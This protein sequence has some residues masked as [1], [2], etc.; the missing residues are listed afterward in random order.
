M[1]YFVIR[2]TIAFVFVFYN[3]FYLLADCPPSSRRVPECG[4]FHNMH[5]AKR[6]RATVDVE[7]ERTG[8]SISRA[9]ISSASNERTSRLWTRTALFELLGWLELHAS[10]RC[11][12]ARAAPVER[13]AIPVQTRVAPMEQPAVPGQ[14]RSALVECSASLGRA[15]AATLSQVRLWGELKRPFRASSSSGN[16]KASVALGK[17]QAAEYSK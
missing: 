8:S 16:F 13:S 2:G 4:S 17:A 1:F 11:G 5:G 6:S 10:S 15:R 3:A 7:I 12:M 14:T 9:P